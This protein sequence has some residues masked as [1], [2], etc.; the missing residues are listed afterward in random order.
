MKNKMIGNNTIKH[1]VYMSIKA[2]S[3]KNHVLTRN[4]ILVDCLN[5]DNLAKS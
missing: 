1:T 5:T 2:L 3:T 4:Q